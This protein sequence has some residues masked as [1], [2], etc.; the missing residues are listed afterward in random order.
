[1]KYRFVSISLAVLVSI[2]GCEIFT[3][4]FGLNQ[5]NL[6]AEIVQITNNDEVQFIVRNTGDEILA[7]V[8][9]RIYFSSDIAIA[10]ND[11]GVHTVFST[12]GA[13]LTETTTIS[14]DDLRDIGSIADGVY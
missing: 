12:I 14:I 1:M 3:D 11:Q 5:P 9:I 6:V 4:L 2:T 7:N 8:E 10:P 13:N